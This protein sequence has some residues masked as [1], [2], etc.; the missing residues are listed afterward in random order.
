MELNELVRKIVSEVLEQHK[1]RGS[2]TACGP[3]WNPVKDT[4]PCIMVLG[5][6]DAHLVPRIQEH[7]GE[8]TEVCFFSDSMDPAANR[9]AKAKPGRYILPYLSCSDMA[10]L[11]SG[12]ASGVFMSEVLRLLLSGTEVE[13]L[14]FAYRSYSETAPVALYALY[15]TYEKTLAGYGLK[16][17]KRKQPDTIRFRD[18]L[19]TATDVSKARENGASTLIIPLTAKITPLAAE[20]ARNLNINILKGL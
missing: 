6:K 1:A 11:A 10:D 2:L 3:D 15:E 14:D 18:S 19:V 7:L 20:A 5:E 13:I 8:D 16:A 17:C 4:R 12:K 9:G